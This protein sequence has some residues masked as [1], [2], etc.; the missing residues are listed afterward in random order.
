MSVVRDRVVGTI[1][2]AVLGWAVLPGLATA[3]P[4]P[5]M[6]QH[7]AFGVPD[8]PQQGTPQQGTPAPSGFLT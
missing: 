2:R 6:A 7:N 8:A 4:A 5:A 3:Q 1:C